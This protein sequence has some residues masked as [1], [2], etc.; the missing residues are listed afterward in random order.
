[1]TL[2]DRFAPSWHFRERHHLTVRAAP[3][4]AYRALRAVTAREVRLFRTLVWLR[5]LGRAGP[6]TILNP[7]PDEPLLDVATRSGFLLLAEAP[8]REIVIGTVVIAPAGAARPVEPEAYRTLSGRGW[9]RGT[10]NFRVEPLETSRC[11][12]TT[13]TRVHASDALT[14]WRFGAYWVL[15]RAGSGLIRR[16]WLRAIARR[17][18]SAE[19]EARSSTA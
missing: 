6:A 15:I 1:V 13:E 19:R 18:R 17:A 9:A 8:G 3:D 7:P 12:V 14:R 16:M 2:L 11:V 10:M 5:R 4:Q